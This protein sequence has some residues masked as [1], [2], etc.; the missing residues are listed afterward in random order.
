VLSTLVL[1]ETTY[2]R[3]PRMLQV[4]HEVITYSSGQNVCLALL[5]SKTAVVKVQKGKV[6]TVRREE[7]RTK[8]DCI[9]EEQQPNR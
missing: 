4:A 3:V 1:E 6:Q 2:T 5:S 7:K 9:T 8:T